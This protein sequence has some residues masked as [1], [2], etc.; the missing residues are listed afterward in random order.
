MI[1]IN[2][3]Y[4]KYLIRIINIRSDISYN[5]LYIFYIYVKPL[6]GTMEIIYTSEHKDFNNCKRTR[7]LG[8]STFSKKL[9]TK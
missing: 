6:F 8:T 1:N 7:E 5:I 3:I 2:L 9:S 4:K